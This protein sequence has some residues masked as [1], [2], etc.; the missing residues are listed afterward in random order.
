MD[1]PAE[2]KAIN[3]AKTFFGGFPDQVKLEGIDGAGWRTVTMRLKVWRTPKIFNRYTMKM[4]FEDP[5]DYPLANDIATLQVRDSLPL[6]F[7]R[8]SKGIIGLLTLYPRVLGP[9]ECDARGQSRGCE[10]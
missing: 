9:T 5:S 1:G 3:D 10:R 6:N 8:H 7:L 4:A 2:T